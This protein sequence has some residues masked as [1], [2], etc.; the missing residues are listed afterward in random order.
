MNK[1]DLLKKIKQ[2]NEYCA[3]Y[4]SEVSAFSWRIAAIVVTALSFF[5][6]CLEWFYWGILNIALL[7]TTATIMSVKHII[8]AFKTRSAPSIALAVL[9]SIA[10]IIMLVLDILS[11]VNGWLYHG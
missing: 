2:D 4:E 5:I 10:F 11:F 6:L 1:E 3:P 8:E 9:A 7:F